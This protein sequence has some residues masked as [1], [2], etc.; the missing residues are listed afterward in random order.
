[1]RDHSGAK[2]AWRAL[3]SAID[4]LVDD[5]ETPRLKLLAKRAH[6]RDCD[7]V[8][9]TAGLQRSDVGACIDL[10]GR[11][12][13]AATMPWQKAQSDISDPSMQDLIRRR[14]PFCRYI[15]PLGVFQRVDCIKA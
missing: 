10:M 12:A 13:V 8:G 7:Y 2:E 9:A 5:D 11:N 1:V 4:E 3:H 14:P 6:G 15:V